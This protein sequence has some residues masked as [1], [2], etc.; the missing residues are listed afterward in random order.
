MRDVAAQV[1][2]LV[3]A[4]SSHDGERF[5]ARA[6]HGTAQSTVDVLRR[7]F[8]DAVDRIAEGTPGRGYAADFQVADRSAD[9]DIDGSKAKKLLP[10][11]EYIPY[12][13][14]VA[15]TARAFVQLL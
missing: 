4:A 6:A 3:D 14:S 15:D 1:T 2:S 13:T 10:R 7:A 12:E 5:I 8:P 11:G 9:V